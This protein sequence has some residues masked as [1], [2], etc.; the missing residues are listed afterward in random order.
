MT[1][2]KI[3]SSPYE[4]K[5]SYYIYDEIK[6]E[7]QDILKNPEYVGRLKAEKLI[8]GFF[9]FIVKEVIDVIRNE[10]DDGKSKIRLYFEGTVD[11]YKAVASVCEESDVAKS[12]DLQPMEKYLNNAYDILPEIVKIFTHKI[13]PIV[14]KS[15]S[16]D[17]GNKQFVDSNLDKFIDASNDVIP[18][19][20]MG[21]YSAG[22]STFINALIGNEILPSG[23]RSVTA[24]IY[25]ILQSKDKN[26]ADIKFIYCN[27][28]IDLHI[29]NDAF[30]LDTD[31]NKNQLVQQIHEEL[32]NVSDIG[33]TPRLNKALSIINS[34]KSENETENIGEIIEIQIPF[35]DG[36]LEKYAGKFVILDTPGSNAASH[37]EHKEI[38]EEA[39]KGMSNGI[40]LYIAEFDKLDTEDNNNLYE[41]VKQMEGLDSRFTMIIVNKADNAD[42]PVNSFT[43]EEIDDI[44]DQAI[45]KKLFS[46]D[47]Y[48][49]SSIIGLGAKN[50]G[51][52]INNHYN[53]TFNKNQVLF[54]DKSNSSYTQLFKYNILT[55]QVR[56]AEMEAAEKESLNNAL[57]A[58]SGLYSIERGI[59]TFASKYSSYNKC[60]QSQL[61]LSKVLEITEAELENSIA[62]RED[63]KKEME[64][65]LELDKQQMIESVEKCSAEEIETYKVLYAPM[66]APILENLK[67]PLSVQDFKDQEKQFTEDQQIKLDMDFKKSDAKKQVSDIGEAFIDG[68]NKIGKAFSIETIKEFGT[69]IVKETKEAIDSNITLFTS[70][71]EVDQAAAKDLIQYTNHNFYKQVEFADSKLDAE[72]QEYW[73]D[74]SMTFKGKLSEVVRN[75]SLSEEKKYEITELIVAYKK[76]EFDDVDNEDMFKVDEFDYLLK[77]GDLKIIKMDKLFLSKLAYSYKNR[78]SEIVDQLDSNIYDAYLNSFIAWKEKLVNIVRTNIVEYSPELKKQQLSINEETKHIHDMQKRQNRLKIYAED[79]TE[80][81]AW[82]NT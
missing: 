47:I 78:L 24:R 26:S 25:K 69:S 56:S 71:R 53:R 13:K 21:N 11:E 20:V 72:A 19:F 4:K 49:V 73:S 23:D 27:S 35:N 37:V 50:K 10:Y 39:M 15:I 79:I 5:I 1:T 54:T 12:I 42:L 58:N 8:N 36:L 33:Y 82:K 14:E 60:Q 30:S 40:P 17:S 75:S 76:L 81:I 51:K 59:L 57:F 66:L 64:S 41:M 55:E 46:S 70:S 22:K 7:W 16:S 32:Y 80:M 31:S 68:V 52:F 61:F 48:F 38:L 67:K 62:S 29:T 63:Y 74:C 28:P 2:I 34:Y 6:K 44:L 45:P 3:I 65:K 43:E 77:L 18:V 9:L